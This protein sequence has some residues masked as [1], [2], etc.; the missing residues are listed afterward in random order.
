MPDIYVAPKSSKKH[1]HESKVEH[2][3]GPDCGCKEH[4]QKPESD[5]KWWHKV[6]ID[7]GET[8]QKAWGSSYCVSP[9]KDYSF[10]TQQPDEEIVLMLRAHPVTNV[11]WILI[12][13]GMLVLPTLLGLTG[14]FTNVPLRFMFVGQLVW[15]L[16]TLMFA[17]EKF[18]DWYY[19]VFIV[20]DQRIVDID[21]LNLLFRVVTQTNLNHIEEAAMVT[22]GFLRSL[23]QYGDVIITTASE[24]PSIE[25]EAVP[26]PDKVVDI[27]NRLAKQLEDNTP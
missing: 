13:F 16:I 26:F 10:I 11:P 5:V 20:T 25:A 18:L 12:T 23:L 2:V 8:S 7:V 17:L 14:I 4:K 22:G 6:L 15:Y 9:P 1:D 27:I 21:F 3:H 19:S 24:S